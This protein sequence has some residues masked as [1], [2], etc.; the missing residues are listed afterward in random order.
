VTRSHHGE[1]E[2]REKGD[3]DTPFSGHGGK[4]RESEKVVSRARISSR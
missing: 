3:F 2:P 4:R 1:A